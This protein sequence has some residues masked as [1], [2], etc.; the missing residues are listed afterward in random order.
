MDQKQQLINQLKEMDEFK[1]ET[2]EDIVVKALAQ[3]LYSKKYK[4]QP[5]QW[6]QGMTK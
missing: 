5:Y 1:S 3:L 2:E 4:D 6:N